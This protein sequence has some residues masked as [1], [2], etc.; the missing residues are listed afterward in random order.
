MEPRLVTAKYS[1]Y[2][3]I[4]RVLNDETFDIYSMNKEDFILYLMRIS[5]GRLNPDTL[6]EI[7]QDLMEEAGLNG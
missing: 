7:Y 3:Y 5:D 4:G 2:K 1:Y 6:S